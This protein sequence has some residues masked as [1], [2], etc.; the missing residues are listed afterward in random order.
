MGIDGH[1][2]IRSHREDNFQLYVKSLKKL[3]PW[4]FALDHQNYASRLPL[5]IL[6]VENL[7]QPVMN[8]F[9]INGHWV[10]HKTKQ[11]ILSHAFRQGA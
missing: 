11:N 3:V 5:H 6:N 2:F 1:V 9:S 4:F 8:E 10:V 7:P